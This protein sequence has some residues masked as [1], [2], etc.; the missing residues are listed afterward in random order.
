VPV[1]LVRFR[2]EDWVDP[3]A[4]P[5]A[6]WS[7]DARVWR[8]LRARI[9][10]LRARQSYQRQHGMT[11]REWARLAAPAPQ[12]LGPADGRVPPR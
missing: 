12:R 10:H 1:E 4:V 6:W 3:D 8:Y 11:R 7:S 2:A 9:A 5:P